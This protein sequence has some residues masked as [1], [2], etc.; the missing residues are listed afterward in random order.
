MNKIIKVKYKNKVL[1]SS[2]KMKILRK[3][4]LLFTENKM[5]LQVGFM[6]HQEDIKFCRTNI[7]L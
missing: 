1:Q 2:S 3:K 7:I 6:K 5:N 4:E